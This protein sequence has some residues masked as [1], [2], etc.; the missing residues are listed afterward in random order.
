MGL[1]VK[2]VFKLSLN[3]VYC[4]TA[5]I[6]VN[7][8]QH[9]SGQ[10]WPKFGVRAEICEKMPAP[11]F[12]AKRSRKRPSTLLIAFVGKHTLLIAIPSGQIWAKLADFGRV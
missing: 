11:P 2:L 4:S 10:I 3:V 1:N 8:V 7:V 12:G 9:C 6:V 5:A